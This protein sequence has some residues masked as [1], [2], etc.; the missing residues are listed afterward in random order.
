[1]YSKDLE[2][3]LS[4]H[5]SLETGSDFEVSIR[6]A[7][8]LAVESIKAAI[9]QRHLDSRHPSKLHVN[10]VLVD[11]WLWD[12]AK[13]VESSKKPLNIRPLPHHRTRSIWY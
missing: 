11:F 2:T 1:M 8:I 7:S 6:A 12:F 5:A 10:S 4:T 3:A 9:V 13:S